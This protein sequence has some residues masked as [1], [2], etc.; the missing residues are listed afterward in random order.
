MKPIVARVHCNGTPAATIKDN[1]EAVW[2]ALEVAI[3]RFREC[4]PNFRDYNG[5]DHY[6]QAV[7]Q[8]ADRVAAVRVVQHDIEREMDA[9]DDQCR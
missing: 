9:I 4:A 6:D 7:K 5:P 1:L 2:D 3:N 8:H